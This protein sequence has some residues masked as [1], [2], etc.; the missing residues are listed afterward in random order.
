MKSR[1]ILTTLILSLAGSSFAANRDSSTSLGMTDLGLSSNPENGH[2]ELAE[3]SRRRRACDTAEQ[4]STVI[5]VPSRLK[6]FMPKLHNEKLAEAK[7][8]NIDVVMIGDSITHARSRHPDALKVEKMLNLGFP[9]D[10][11]QNVLWRLQ[12]GAVDGI[13]PRL[14]TLLIGTNHMHDPKKGYTP[15]A[16]ADIFTGIQAVVAELRTR[17]PKAKIIVFSVFPR[18][19]GGPNDRVSALNEMLPRIADGRH[20]FHEDINRTFLGVRGDYNSALYSRD[21]LHLNAD[22]YAAWAKALAPILKQEGLGH[23]CDARVP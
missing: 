18:K 13:A 23:R 3:A 20:V 22:G 12:H 11:T 7:A 19:P 8:G 14:V 17:L 16:T 5:P 9:G 15:D 2:A 6:K 4:P 1:I 10:R 21:G